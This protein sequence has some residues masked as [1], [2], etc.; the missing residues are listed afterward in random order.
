MCSFWSLGRLV[1]YGFSAMVGFG[2]RSLACAE[3][4]RWMPSAQR[5]DYA[6]VKTLARL[7]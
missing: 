7:R 1:R 4:R 3:K 5:R 6:V 2:G